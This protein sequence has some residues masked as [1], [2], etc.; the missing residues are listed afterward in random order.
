M[1]INE[2]S[3]NTYNVPIYLWK[4]KIEQIGCISFL[5]QRPIPPHSK[6]R[7]LAMDVGGRRAAAR[8]ALRAVA[9]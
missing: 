7:G 8:R 6:P 1:N 9:L 5:H 2:F 4:D 3:T